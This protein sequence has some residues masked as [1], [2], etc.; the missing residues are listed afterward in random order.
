MDTTV[1][2]SLTDWFQESHFRI[3]LKNEGW[4]IYLKFAL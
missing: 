1:I 3:D 2:G 4:T